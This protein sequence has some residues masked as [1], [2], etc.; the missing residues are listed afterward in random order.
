[1]NAHQKPA[2]EDFKNT[3]DLAASNF[4]SGINAFFGVRQVTEENSSRIFLLRILMHDWD[5][6]LPEC[7]SK[8]RNCKTKTNDSTLILYFKN[9]QKKDINAV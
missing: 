4:T 9:L 8:E 2:K 1:L 5:I 6:Q 7:F 3:D